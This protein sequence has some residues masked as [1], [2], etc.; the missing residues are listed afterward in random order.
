MSRSL[1]MFALLVILGTGLAI[2]AGEAIVIARRPVRRAQ[3]ADCH[4][5]QTSYA[6]APVHYRMVMP[7]S[8]TRSFH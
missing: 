5:P 6:P 7:L 8:T 4:A 1:S 2:C 3:C